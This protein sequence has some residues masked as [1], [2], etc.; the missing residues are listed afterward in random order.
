MP[1]LMMAWR[2][3]ALVLLIPVLALAL[4]D[5]PGD[6]QRLSGLGRPANSI[7][8]FFGNTMPTTWLITLDATLSFSMLVA[9][10]A[11]WQWWSLKRRE[12]DE[13]SKMIIG[14]LFTIAGGLCLVIAA[15]TRR[16]RRQ[17]RPVL[18]ARCSTSSTASASPT[19]C[20]VSL[21]LF[22]KVAPKA[23]NATVIGLYY[24][25]FFA[26]NALVG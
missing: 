16:G 19:S 2:V 17:D 12:P 23:I 21:A 3:I 25:A 6:L 8:T 7:S 5:Q 4:L 1:P 15:S 18:A 22:S 24:L 26:A 9:V 11:F 10:A 20:P 13:L 14:S